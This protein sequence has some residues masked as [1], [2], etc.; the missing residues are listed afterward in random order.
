MATLLMKRSPS[1]NIQN[2]TYEPDHKELVVEFTS[3]AV[4]KYKNVGPST[5]DR[6]GRSESLGSMFN[7]LIR[8]YPKKYPYVKIS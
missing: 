7:R 5:F 6:L 4:Y 8:K 2:M 1:S 3:G